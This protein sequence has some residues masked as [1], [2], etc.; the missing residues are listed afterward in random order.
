METT[1]EG[2]LDDSS[3]DHFSPKYEQLRA[4]I[5]SEIK[6]GR[7]RPGDML[8][9]E[10]TMAEQMSVARSTVRQALAELEQAGIVRRIRGKGTFIHDECCISRA[11]CSGL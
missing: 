1:F 9:P 6:A 5:M 7:L 2:L 4:K 10:P 11:C 3:L 8:P